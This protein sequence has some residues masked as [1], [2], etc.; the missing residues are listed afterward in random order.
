M[1]HYQW[2]S[3]EEVFHQELVKNDLKKWLGKNCGDHKGG[4]RC[5]GFRYISIN[6]NH[7]NFV[8]EFKDIDATRMAVALGLSYPISNFE[9]IKEFYKECEIE[10]IRPI[11]AKT[12]MEDNY[13]SKDQV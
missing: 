3:E 2:L 4:D 7:K 8:T 13:T 12:D 9:E 10:D 6:N 11:M 5:Q 1:K